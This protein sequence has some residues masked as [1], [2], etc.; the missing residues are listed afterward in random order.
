MCTHYIPTMIQQ[1]EELI[2]LIKDDEIMQMKPIIY[3]CGHKNLYVAYKSEHNG[4]K[5]FIV[6]GDTHPYAYVMC[7]DKFIHDHKNRYGGLDCI[8]VHGGV[9]WI[10]EVDRLL[11]HPKEYSGICFGWD[12]GHLY[13]W[14]GYYTDEQNYLCGLHKYTTMEIKTECIGVIN[15]YL[16]VLEYHENQLQ[17]HDRR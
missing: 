13:D 1:N 8:N 14:N 9:T 5:Y 7:D 2:R 15:Q 17:S 12:Y 16:E 10:G 3:S 11:C 4:I 6:A